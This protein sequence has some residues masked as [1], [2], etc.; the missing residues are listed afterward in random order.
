MANKMYDL[1]PNRTLKVHEI[2]KYFESRSVSIKI[3]HKAI[4]EFELNALTMLQWELYQVVP[5]NFLEIF[6][7]Y[8]KLG[9]IILI[10]PHTLINE[11]CLEL[12]TGTFNRKLRNKSINGGQEIKFK[13]I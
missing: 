7:Y 12:I 8:S 5:L 13:I 11:N 2:V 9:Q 10:E 3:N 1:R 4:K 6:Q